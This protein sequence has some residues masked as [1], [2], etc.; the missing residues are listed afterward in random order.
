MLNLIVI[1]TLFSW[2]FFATIW[3]V[4]CWLHHDFENYGVEGWKPCVVDVYSFS[5]AFL[6]SLETQ[7]TIGYG[8]R[9]TTGNCN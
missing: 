7:H 4:I 9:S 1:E 5:S 6:F 3:Y 2:T 8:S